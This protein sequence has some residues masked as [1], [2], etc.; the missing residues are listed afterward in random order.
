VINTI[1]S[2]RFSLTNFNMTGACIK[3]SWSVVLVIDSL[4]FMY[5]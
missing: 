4:R 2:A 1:G 3:F 5:L